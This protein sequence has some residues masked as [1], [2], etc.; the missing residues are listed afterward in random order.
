MVEKDSGEE[1]SVQ[2]HSDSQKDTKDTNM[3]V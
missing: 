2:I 1:S 3:K